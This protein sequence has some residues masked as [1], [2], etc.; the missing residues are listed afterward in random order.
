M[1]AEVFAHLAN[2]AGETPRP[3]VRDGRVQ[4]GVA[5]L[6]HDLLHLLLDDRV[7]DLH[8][9]A[10]E[11]CGRRIHLHAAE[12][13]AA[14]A[15]TTGAPAD[16][17]DQVAGLSF[18]AVRSTWDQPDTASEYERIGGVAGVIMHR[19]V[20]GRD[21]HLVAVVFDTVDD[22]RDDPARMQDVVRQGVHRCIG[23]AEAQHVGV[24]DGPRA[25]PQHVA[26]HAARAGVRAAERL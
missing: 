7:A 17:D 11:L 21:A 9:A 3:A 6:E 16:D 20:H 22:A 4:A 24:G 1:R 12:R 23:Q 10:G 8:R 25:D 18:R 26:D 13:R 19:A 15:I 5:R 2:G 14:Q